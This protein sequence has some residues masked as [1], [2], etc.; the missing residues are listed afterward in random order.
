MNCRDY[1]LRDV[2]A[3]IKDQQDQIAILMGTQH[4]LAEML[5]ERKWIS[6]KERYPDKEGFYLVSDGDGRSR[7]WIAKMLNLA[8]TKGFCNDAAAPMIRAWMPLPEPYN[9]QDNERQ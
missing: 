3:T 6:V 7:P 9:G 8:G 4:V 5:Q 1:M 2:L